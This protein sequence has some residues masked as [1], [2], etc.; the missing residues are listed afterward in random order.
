MILEKPDRLISGS[1]K[2]VK[3]FE[4]KT[5]MELHFPYLDVY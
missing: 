1:G 3:I 2:K 4:K 5:V